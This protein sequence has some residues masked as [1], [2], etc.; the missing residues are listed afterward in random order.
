MARIRIIDDWLRCPHCPP[1]RWR[2]IMVVAEQWAEQRVLMRAYAESADQTRP[3]IVLHG[4]ELAIGPAGTDPHGAWGIHVHP[5]EDGRAQQLA[6]ALRAAAR[7]LAGGRARLADEESEFDRKR[8]DNWAPGDAP[9]LPA[10]APRPYHEPMVAASQSGA[11]AY[12]TAPQ[13]AYV[14]APQAAYVPAQAPAAYLGAS[15]VPAAPPVIAAAPANPQQRLT[16]VPIAPGAAAGHPGDTRPG[17]RRRGWTSPVPSRGAEPGAGRTA[18]GYESGAGAQSAIVRLGLRPAAA[19]QL[20]RLAQRT[21]PASFAISAPERDVLNRLAE[22]DLLSARAIGQL[23]GAV[24]PVAWMEQLIRKLDAHGLDLVVPGP[25]LGD[26]P[27][28]RLQR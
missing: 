18:L 21:V 2:S 27:T 19:S 1:T 12:V 16:P 15:G 6:E 9:A 11:P 22:V 23:V 7:R 26:E 17:R 20:G 8:T 5:Q 13:A 10:A 25:P 14:P 24:D 28:Y 3:T 4:V